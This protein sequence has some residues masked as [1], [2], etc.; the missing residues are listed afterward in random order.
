MPTRTE[1]EKRCVVLRHTLPDGTA[2][3]DWMIEREGA[4]SD[5][6]TFRIELGTELFTAGEFRAERIGNHR[7][8]YLEYEGPVSGDRGRVERIARLG[9]L[10]LEESDGRVR[11]VLEREGGDV[12]MEWI[13]NR[14][15]GACW[16]FVGVVC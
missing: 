3:L 10:K 9:V 13:G 6:V 11:V 2:H 4:A 12:R 1:P 8:A 5:L 14:E 15:K 16:K 7:R